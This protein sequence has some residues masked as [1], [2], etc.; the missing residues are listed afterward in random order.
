MSV[1]SRTEQNTFWYTLTSV[2]LSLL[3]ALKRKFVIVI[4][5]KSVIPIY[6]LTFEFHGPRNI[7]GKENEMA[8]FSSSGLIQVSGGPDIPNRFENNVFY[9][10]NVKLPRRG[11]CSRFQL[12]S[13]AALQLCSHSEDSSLKKHVNNTFSNQFLGFWAT[14]GFERLGLCMMSYMEP[15]L[16]EVPILQLFTRMLQRCFA[17]SARKVL[18]TTKLPLCFHRHEGEKIMTE[19]NFTFG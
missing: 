15:I 7:S 16:K 17:S 8:P 9:T 10:F 3:C 2:L 13:F 6:I 18:W 5:I 1:Q 19:C 11:V 4:P 14:Q 12:C